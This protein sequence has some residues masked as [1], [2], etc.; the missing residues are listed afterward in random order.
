[1]LNKLWLDL[2]ET[3][4]LSALLFSENRCVTL[5]GKIVTDIDTRKILKIHWGNKMRL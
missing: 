1:M 5:Q 2:E 4:N 3:L